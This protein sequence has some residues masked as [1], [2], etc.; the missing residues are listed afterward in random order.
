MATVERRG[1][2]FRVIFYDAGWRYTASL[3]TANQRDADS[4]AGSVDRTLVLMQQGVL[5]LPPGA[6]LVTFVVSGGKCN[7]KPKPPPI[8]T[9]SDLKERYLQAVG[10]GSMEANSFDTVK[11][12]TWAIS[13]VAW[14][15]SSPS[16][17]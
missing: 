14:A 9:L 17:L 13:Y 7:E 8:R 12:C 6:D 10:S 15:R 3:K 2:R 1:K 16:K 5:A 11:K 4:V